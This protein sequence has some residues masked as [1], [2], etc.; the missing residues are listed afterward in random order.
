[1]IY[2]FRCS[3]TRSLFETGKTRRWSAIVTVATRKLAMLDAA[4]ELR[5]LG[6]PPGNKLK[7]LDGDRQGQHSIRINDQYRICFVWGLNGPESVEIV[8]YH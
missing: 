2:S 5:D 6:S 3:D 4:V 7:E 8:D 1:M